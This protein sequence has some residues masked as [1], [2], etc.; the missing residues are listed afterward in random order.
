MKKLLIAVAMSVL[1]AGAYAT[2]QSVTEGNVAVKNA[3]TAEGQATQSLIDLNKNANV[4]LPLPRTYTESATATRGTDS[5][6]AS[7]TKLNKILSFGG[8]IK[9]EDKV[10]VNEWF[11]KLLA[12]ELVG[13]KPTT[14]ESGELSHWFPNLETNEKWRVTGE[15]CQSYNCIAWSVGVTG[16]WLWP[17]DHVDSFD[18]MYLSYGYVPLSAGESK[19]NADIAY[20]ETTDGAS[21]HGCRRVAGDIWESKLGSS[22]R[23][24]HTLKDLEGDVYGYSVKFY[25]RATTG[26]LAALGV[27]PKTPDGNGSDPCASAKRK[28][29][30][31]G[32][33]DLGSPSSKIRR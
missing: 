22:L 5:E 25:R 9:P 30:R 28:V 17:G 20:W 19:N 29:T 27:T 2:E 18:K 31:N 12:K 33:Y 15:A 6:A 13:R 26:E 23:I 24:L 4:T 11:P 7:L 16:D 14:F 3:L 21:T 1:T 32:A 8:G 10:F